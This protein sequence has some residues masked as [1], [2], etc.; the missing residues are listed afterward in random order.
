LAH[1]LAV[2]HEIAVVGLISSFD[3]IFLSWLLFAS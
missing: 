3:H 1:A 2:D